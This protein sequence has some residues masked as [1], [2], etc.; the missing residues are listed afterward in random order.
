MKII[1]FRRKVL[2]GAIVIAAA[3]GYLGYQGFS[4]GASYYY[5]V[6]EFVAQQS[7]LVNEKTRLNGLVAPGSVE[8][9]GLKLKFDVTNEGGQIKVP[10]VY[11][12]AVPDS[13]K[14]GGEITIEGNLNSSGVFVAQTLMPKCPSKYVPVVN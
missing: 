10:V 9:A 14:A 5:T 4:S 13:F 6:D 8:Q 12:G 3:L 7:S 1:K 11:E 2:I